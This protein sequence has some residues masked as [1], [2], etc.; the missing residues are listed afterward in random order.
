MPPKAK[1]KIEDLLKNGRKKKKSGIRGEHF[2]VVVSCLT[3]RNGG[4][5]E[6]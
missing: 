3:S 5:K 6:I 2:D 4:V 1:A